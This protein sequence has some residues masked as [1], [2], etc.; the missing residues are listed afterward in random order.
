MPSIS[1]IV[2]RSLRKHV[3]PLLRETGFGKVDARNGWLWRPKIIWVFAIRAVGGQFNFPFGG[4]WP[5]CS[6]HA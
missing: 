6:I 4:G 1:A 3:V 2:N 5:P